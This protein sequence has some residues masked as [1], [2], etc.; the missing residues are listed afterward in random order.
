L[1]DKPAR[2]EATRL[3]IPVIGT[4]GV[5]VLARERELIPKLEPVLAQLKRCGFHC[6]EALYALLLAEAGEGEE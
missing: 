1:D 3:G 2:L 4:L 6:S 5:L